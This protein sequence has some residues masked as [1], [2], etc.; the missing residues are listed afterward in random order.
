MDIKNLF[1]KLGFRNT[2]TL[3]FI[4]FLILS[5]AVGSLIS[6]RKL[7]Y[8]NQAAESN[9]NQVQN[10]NYQT[11]EIIIKLKAPMINIRSKDGKNLSPQLDVQEIEYSKIDEKTLPPVLQQI[12]H[13]NAISNIKRIEKIYKGYTDPKTESNKIRSMFSNGKTNSKRNID[14]N[15]LNNIDLSAIYKLTL[16]RNLPI[17]EIKNLK[18]NKDV[19]YAEPNFI[20]KTQLIPNDPYYLS[21]GSW[22]QAYDDLW[23]LKK[24]NAENAWDINTGSTNITIAVI[25]TGLDR[26]HEDIDENV[27]TNIKEIPDNK[28]DDDNNGYIDDYYGWDFANNDNNPIDDNGHGTHTAGTIAAFGNNNKGIVGVNWRAK[29]V[30]IKFLSS[31]GSGLLEDAALALKYAADLGVDISSNSWGG[32]NSNLIEDALAYQH[33]LGVTIIAA[34]GNSN[35]DA[36]DFSPASSDYAITVAASDPNDLKALFSNWGEKIDIAA[37][38]VDILSLKASTNTMCNSQNTVGEKYCRVSG[39]SM[40]TPHVS[41]LAALLLTNNP[42]YTNEQLRQIIRKSALDLGSAGKDR[43]FGYGR[44]N[45]NNALRVNYQPLNLFLDSPRSTSTISGNYSIIGTSDGTKFKNYKLEVGYGRFPNQWITFSES[46]TLVTNGLLGNLNTANFDDGIIIIRLTATDADNNQFQ[47]QVNDIKINNFNL[48]IN[49]PSTFIGKG[50]INIIGHANVQPNSGLIF[51]NYIL[52]WG[53]GKN[54]VT[55]STAGIILAN[56]GQQPVENGL[57]ATWNT[58]SLNG[59]QEYVLKLTVKAQNTHQASYSVKLILNPNIRSGWPAYHEGENLAA[60]AVTD[61][62]NDGEKEIIQ[63]IPIDCGFGSINR[64]GKINVWREDGTILDGWPKPLIACPWGGISI[65]D[66]ENDIRKEIIVPTE[67]GLYI[68]DSLGNNLYGSPFTSFSSS[69]APILIDLDHDGDLEI[70]LNQIYSIIIIHHD[71]R[72]FVGDGVFWKITD[73]ENEEITGLVCADLNKD[74]S[75]DIIAGVGGETGTRVYAW[76]ID[77]TSIPGW[78]VFTKP[79]TV[80]STILSSPS[81]GDV[82]NDGNL[83]V[84]INTQNY[85]YLW[86]KNGALMP[87]WPIPN[88]FSFINFMQLPPVLADLDNDNDLEIISYNDINSVTINGYHHTGSTVFSTIIPRYEGIIGVQ[89]GISASDYNNDNDSEIFVQTTQRLIGLN[90]DGSILPGFPLFFPNSNSF[91]E[92]APVIDDIDNDG[93][94][95]IITASDK[96]FIFVFNMDTT[97][98]QSKKE[99]PMYKHDLHHTGN[100]SFNYPTPLPIIPTSTPIPSPIL[101]PTP[102]PRPVIP[103]YELLPNEEIALGNY[104][105]TVIGTPI[106]NEGKMK[107]TYQTSE[108]SSSIL[109]RRSY[110]A[111]SP[112][113]PLSTTRFAI[114][115]STSIQT[116]LLDYGNTGCFNGGPATMVVKIKN[117]SSKPITLYYI[118]LYGAANGKMAEWGTPPPTPTN[119]PTPIPT[120]SPGTTRPYYIRTRNFYGTGYNCQRVDACGKSNCLPTPLPKPTIKTGKISTKTPT[121]I[122]IIVR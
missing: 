47:S 96:N 27:W 97:L 15:S 26:N 8:K 17:D 77:K 88:P 112:T 78:P 24:T 6:S 103:P 22:N 39:T 7:T 56:N 63:S 11:G 38:G 32:P 120:C 79:E 107:I 21:K 92:R 41:G 5:L 81:I 85:L 2:F 68:F 59:S 25:D 9:I 3:F 80:P 84:V 1:G 116:I 101:S 89:T 60:P 29:L 71:G 100:Y 49:S 64:R 14:Y 118:Y 74:G 4:L 98:N 106:N 45:F 20:Y 13:F 122:R 117:I 16:K 53:L 119:T 65:G 70:I 67:A 54:P 51:S 69:Y 111:S 102:S 73:I 52:E 18:Q 12:N 87:N 61:I 86:Q 36:L 48:A 90:K 113:S 114:P 30:G 93:K 66:L 35:A 72:P 91:R 108:N 82:N 40:A 10:L 99:W 33:A 83:E 58:N 37:P 121:P 75:P 109:E 50:N 55:W 44:I 23:G 46:S 31:S 110:F 57:L 42:N 28:I 62:N 34:A 19:V 76:N 95:E 104:E 115:A 105:N 94:T 43:D